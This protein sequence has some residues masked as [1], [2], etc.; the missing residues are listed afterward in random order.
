MVNVVANWLPGIS[1]AANTCVPLHLQHI[2]LTF[3]IL[4]SQFAAKLDLP[5]INK[6]QRAD[7]LRI[8]PWMCRVANAGVAKKSHKSVY[9]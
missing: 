4:E 8:L 9:Y 7:V 3:E 2:Q 5:Y 6:N 1:K